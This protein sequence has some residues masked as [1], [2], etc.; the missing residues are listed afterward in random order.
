[1]RTGNRILIVVGMITWA[2]TGYAQADY[3]FKVLANK[4]A[5]EYKTGDTW[6]PIKTGI[7]LNVGDEL[8]VSENAYLGLVSKTGKPLE[9]K[10]PNNYKV[11]DLLNQLGTGTSVMAKYTDFILSSNSAEAKKNRLSATG[12]VHRGGPGA[13][14]VYLPGSQTAVQNNFLYN[15]SMYV[16]WEA[17]A[18]GGPYVVTLLDFME[19]EL[20]KVETPE[21][22][23]RL[24]LSDPKLAKVTNFLVKVSS[25]ADSKVH[26]EGNAVKR[27]TAAEHEKIRKAYEEIP[28]EW[29]DNSAFMKYSMAGFYEQHALLIDALSCYEEAIHMAPDVQDFVDARNEF[30]IRNN[31]VQVKN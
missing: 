7:S 2:V 4:G 5:N 1:M 11:A 8:K 23:V 9:I 13:L 16:V 18:S 31:L 19:E 22:N 21:T 17:P 26:S 14:N 3:A 20:M 27:M 25:K 30:L 6:Q 12:A 15:N 24:D 29:K 28:A 10:K